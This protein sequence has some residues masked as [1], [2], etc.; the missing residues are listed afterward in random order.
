MSGPWTMTTARYGDEHWNA[1]ARLRTDVFVVEQKVPVEL[2]LDEWDRR[3]EHLAAYENGE[4]VGTLRLVDKD[5]T[6][7][8]GRVAVRA[9]RRGTGVGRAMMQWALRRARERGFA[10][11]LVESQIQV[12]GFYEKL[13]FVRRGGTFLDAGIPH[14]RL[15]LD[16]PSHDGGLP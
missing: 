5:G 8:I 12:R 7:K 2:E 9:D 6:V 4:L 1:I 3:V 11:A 13:G 14:V 15:F 16:F 10:A